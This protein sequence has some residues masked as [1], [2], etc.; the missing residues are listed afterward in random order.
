MK[1]S[2]AAV[3]IRW[4]LESVGVDSDIALHQGFELV[5]NFTGLAFHKGSYF[6][7]EYLKAYEA[8]NTVGCEADGCEATIPANL[9]FCETHQG[10]NLDALVDDYLGGI[11]RQGEPD[12][13]SHGLS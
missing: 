11:A 10:G 9:L 7:N 2:E 6:H 13:A 8:L 4:A 3:N 12:P 1:D 5:A